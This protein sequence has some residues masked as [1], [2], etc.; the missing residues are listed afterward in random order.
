MK[1]YQITERLK[2]V[3]ENVHFVLLLILVNWLR[4]WDES[5]KKTFYIFFIYINREQLFLQ[6]NENIFDFKA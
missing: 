6:Y 2:N 4:L 5:L 1:G 3:H